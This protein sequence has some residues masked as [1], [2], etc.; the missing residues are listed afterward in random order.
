MR[1]EYLLSRE[2]WRFGNARSETV[3]TKKTVVAESST[4]SLPFHY[5]RVGPGE[6]PSYP[7]GTAQCARNLTY[8]TQETYKRKEKV[9]RNADPRI[10]RK[11]K[12]AAEAVRDK[13]SFYN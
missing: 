9:C 10:K 12:R 6:I 5:D 8:W 11:L 2:V 4:L 7:P 1:L 3:K 13:T